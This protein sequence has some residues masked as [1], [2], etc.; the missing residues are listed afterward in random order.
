MQIKQHSRCLKT[1]KYEP[2]AKDKALQILLHI[3]ILLSMKNA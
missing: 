1:A 2:A 3:Q